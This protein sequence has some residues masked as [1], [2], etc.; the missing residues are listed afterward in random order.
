[1][2]NILLEALRANNPKNAYLYESNGT[3]IAYK[4]GF[5]TL[6]YAMGYNVNVYGDKGEFLITYPMIGITAGS[7][8]TMIGKA[9]TGK[10][11]AA[12]QFAASIIKNFPSSV[13]FHYD[14]EG[15]SNM[16]R[17]ATITKMPINVLQDKWVIRQTHS[18]IEEIKQSIADV[19]LEKTQNPDKYMYDTG[20]VDEFGKPIHTYEPTCVIIDSVPSM[21]TYIN[22]NTKDGLK[23]LG[24]ISS[25][26]DQMRLTAEITR[27]LKEILSMIKSANITV[28]LINHIKE[29]PPMGTP[30]Q[31]ELRCLKQ[32]ETLPAGKALQ[33]YTNTM[34]RYTSVGAEKYTIEDDGFEGF[35]VIAS[36]VKNR[37]NTDGVAVPIV[38]DKQRGFDSIRSSVR[39]AKEYGFVNGNRNGYYFGDNKDHKFTAKTIHDDF[40]N[41]RELYKI[42]YGY[43]IPQLQS[44]LVTIRPEEL[45]IPDEEMD[46]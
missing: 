41:D 14:L 6:D 16:T 22:E 7:M 24:E 37:T 23:T 30:Q 38:F 26:T 28:F 4:T 25:Q 19:Y 8:V 1:M 9:H 39:F 2:A 31:A 13:C 17:I 32:N 20:K 42:L 33:Y 44:S 15:G 29:K 10:T 43:I 27:F 18:S 45:Y 21:G 3:F 11:T 46:Y 34:I 40:M 5:P 35:G 36:F 12:I